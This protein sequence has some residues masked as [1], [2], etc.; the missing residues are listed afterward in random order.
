MA[1]C[2]WH[3]RPTQILIVSLMSLRAYFFCWA[4][5]ELRITLVLMLHLSLISLDLGW[6]FSL[7]HLL[8]HWQFWRVQSIN[9]MSTNLGLSDIFSRL[10]SADALLSGIWCCVL[11]LPYQEAH[12]VNVLLLMMLPLITCLSHY[13][14]FSFSFTSLLPMA[15]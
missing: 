15:D 13:L 11:G 14:L 7:F 3:I 9:F 4:R 1:Q 5:I 6:V 2:Y 10:V 8:R 12:G